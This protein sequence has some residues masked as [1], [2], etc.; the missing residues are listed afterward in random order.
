MKVKHTYYP[1]DSCELI[2]KRH[3]SQFKTSPSGQRRIKMWS[4][5]LVRNV[6]VRYHSILIVLKD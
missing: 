4:N 6:R 3:L 2:G 5:P 1:T